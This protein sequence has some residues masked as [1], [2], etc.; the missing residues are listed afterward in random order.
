MKVALNLEHEGRLYVSADVWVIRGAG[1]R[2]WDARYQY[3]TKAGAWS[4]NA[5]LA[6]MREGLPEPVRVAALAAARDAYQERARLA[7]A[8]AE[9]CAEALP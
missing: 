6:G 8:A 1:A 7:Q 4:Q 3:R 2:V 5:R 9:A